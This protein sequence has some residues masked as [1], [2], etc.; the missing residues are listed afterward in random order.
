MRQKGSL[1][2][3]P[4]VEQLEAAGERDLAEAVKSYGGWLPVSLKSNMHVDDY[5]HPAS[6][7]STFH[8]PRL[9]LMDRGGKYTVGVVQ[10][11]LLMN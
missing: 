4:T 11:F 3:F 6:P 1:Q 7:P 9:E 2:S 8:A 5:S 10:V